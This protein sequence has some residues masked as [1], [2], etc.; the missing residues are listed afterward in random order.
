MAILTPRATAK[1]VMMGKITIKTA[2]NSFLLGGVGT[3]M[4]ASI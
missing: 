2:L 1:S 4:T 3:W